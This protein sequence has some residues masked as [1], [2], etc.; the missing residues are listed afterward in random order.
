LNDKTDGTAEEANHPNK[1]RSMEKAKH[2][3]PFL[4]ITGFINTLYSY[5]ANGVAVQQ[6]GQAKRP[7]RSDC[8]GWLDCSVLQCK[9][10]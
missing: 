3:S 10:H 7:P 4:Q 2:L 6:P 9:K 8:N 1:H 5:L